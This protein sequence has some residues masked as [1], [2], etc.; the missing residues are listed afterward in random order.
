MIDV[1][2]LL[3]AGVHFGHPMNRW[4]PKMS[5]YIFGERSNIYIIDLQKTV[6]KFAE[7]EAFIKKIVANGQSILFVGTKKQAQVAIEEGTKQCGM[8]HVTQRW[9]GGMLTNFTTIRK[10][11]DRLKKIE[12]GR[13]DGTNERRPKKE[14]IQI[15]KQW[16]KLDKILSGIRQMD[17]LPGAIFIVDPL[18]EQICV[19]EARRLKIPLIAMVDTNCDPDQIDYVIP[20]NDDGIKSI[21]F[22]TQK[23]VEAIMEGLRMRE[24]NLAA[25]AVVPQVVAPTPEPP[26]NLALEPAVVA[27]ITG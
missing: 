13:T 21:R 8:F 18:R 1:K 7:A 4:N 25:P 27:T 6:K 12:K 3:D 15:E 17:R 24:A 16:G 9:L 14:V 26:V 23:V 10:S 2:E 22:V 5:R 20:A 11:V 19:A